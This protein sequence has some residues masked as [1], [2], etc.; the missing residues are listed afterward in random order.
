MKKL[1]HN[2]RSTLL[3]TLPICIAAV[4]CSSQK[5]ATATVQPAITA[6]SP[7]TAV[8]KTATAESGGIIRIKAGVTSP[9]T[10][11]AGHLWQADQ[12]FD[13]GDVTDRDAS[14]TIA[15]TKDPALFLSEHYGMNSFSCKLP[16]GK[17]TA[18]LYFAETF[19]GISGPGERVFSFN[20]QGHEFKNFDVWAKAGGPNKAY[21]ETVPVEVNNGVFRIDFTSNIENPEINA[22]ELIPH[23]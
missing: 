9:F 10:D 19:E 17:Y 21:V 12:G 15:G 3:M 4:G 22:I 8:A 14:T 11:S 16:N 5:N 1:S 7:T 20:V 18:N 13:G 23:S 2:L 6:S